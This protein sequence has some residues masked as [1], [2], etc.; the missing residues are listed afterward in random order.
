[1]LHWSQPPIASPVVLQLNIVSKTGDAHLNWHRGH[2]LLFAQNADAFD[3]ATILHGRALQIITQCPGCSLV[4]N[5]VGSPRIYQAQE[6][7]RGIIHS[8]L[9]GHQPLGHEY[10]LDRLPD[11]IAIMR[12]KSFFG[13]VQ[14]H[15]IYAFLRVL[16]VFKIILFQEFHAHHPVHFKAALL[17]IQALGEIDNT[18]RKLWD[19]NLTVNPDS[20]ETHSLQCDVAVTSHSFCSAICC[21]NIQLIAD[22]GCKKVCGEP[23]VH[24]KIKGAS[25]SNP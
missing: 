24:K 1:M 8:D 5:T 21:H 19:L 17:G 15:H 11:R 4:H 9:H 22:L 20:S 3:S 13:P 18:R 7:H 16:C 10:S 25:V 6:R 12:L 14:I 2:V 23:R